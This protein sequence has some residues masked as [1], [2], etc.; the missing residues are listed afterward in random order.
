M[1]EIV[2]HFVQK[3]VPINDTYLGDNFL[4]WSHTIAGIVIAVTFAIIGALCIHGAGKNIEKNSAYNQR[5]TMTRLFGLFLVACGISRGID[6]VCLFYNYAYLSFLA[7]AATAAAS[8]FAIAYIP[9]VF[10]AIRESKT[11]EEV[12]HTLKDTNEKIDKLT[13]LKSRGTK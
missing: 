4:I 12:S 5:I 11:L 8:T 9:I 1:K 2:H 7:K 6:V 10:K 3:F 13:D